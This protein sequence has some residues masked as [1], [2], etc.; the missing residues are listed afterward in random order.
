MA[1]VLC[2]STTGL[3]APVWRCICRDHLKPVWGMCCVRDCH[4]RHALGILQGQ[5]LLRQHVTASSFVV[6]FVPDTAIQAY[7]SGRRDLSWSARGCGFMQKHS[8]CLHART[9]M[10]ILQIGMRTFRIQFCTDHGE[11]GVSP[12]IIVYFF[13]ISVVVW[14]SCASNWKFPTFHLL[15][16]ASVFSKEV[17]KHRAE[18]GKPQTTPRKP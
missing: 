15:C 6:V 13:S 16:T 8:S 14:G 1:G 9:T 3:T 5:G 12:V 7:P 18:I 2:R 10:W 4:D 17:R 11:E